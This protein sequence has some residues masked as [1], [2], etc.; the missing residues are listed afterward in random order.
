MTLL[1]C[2]YCYKSIKLN[3]ANFKCIHC[4]GC[5]HIQCVQVRDTN[6]NGMFICDQCIG[7]ELPFNCIIHDDEFMNAILEHQQAPSKFMIEQL[8]ELLFDPFEMN[9]DICDFNED[10]YE[11]LGNG[12]NNLNCKYYD[13]DNFVINVNVPVSFS[14]MHMN[15]RSVSK[16]FHEFT[17]LLY[18]MNYNFTIIGLS[19]TWFTSQNVDCY[20]LLGYNIINDLRTNRAGGGAS[21]L[22]RNSIP[23]ALRSDLKVFGASIECIFY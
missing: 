12:I 23:Y 18:C 14:L 6:M 1:N 3:V 11:Y 15:I 21:L 16:H 9:E 22:I 13:A 19:E 20:K 7:Q 2:L 10:D 17:L 8:N 5:C 4:S